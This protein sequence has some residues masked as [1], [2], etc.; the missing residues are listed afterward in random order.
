MYDGVEKRRFARTEINAVVQYQIADD[1][2]MRDG[3]LG[4]ISAGGILLWTEAELR[5]GT[6]LYLRISAD[7]LGDIEM[8]VTATIVRLDPERLNGQFGYG[9]K[10]DAIYSGFQIGVS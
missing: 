10:F 4:N 5:V 9:C 2:T 3:W 7:E 6:T 1:E 8:E